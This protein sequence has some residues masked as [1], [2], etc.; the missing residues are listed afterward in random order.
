MCGEGADTLFLDVNERNQVIAKKLSEVDIHVAEKCSVNYFNLRYTK[1]PGEFVIMD[2]KEFDIKEKQIES[3]PIPVSCDL[4]PTPRYLKV[5]THLGYN[6]GP[7]CM[8][9][10]LDE[11]Y[12][13]LRVRPRLFHEYSD[14]NLSMS[15]FTNG[16]DKFYICTSRRLGR[17][18]YLYVKDNDPNGNPLGN[19]PPDNPRY[20]LACKPF[21]G[22]GGSDES[23]FFRLVRYESMYISQSKA[24]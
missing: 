1:N 14:V 24:S 9:N 10:S 11:S 18:G 2:Y 19:N 21:I 12:C 15:D 20:T 13:R 22:G 8:E 16:K 3:N 7:L 23:M 4:W 17:T 5:N 6:N